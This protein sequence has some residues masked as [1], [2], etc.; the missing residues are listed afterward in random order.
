MARV[1]QHIVWR[2]EVLAYDIVRVLMVPFSLE[3][4]SKFAGKLVGFIGPKTSKHHIAHT[5]MKLAFPDASEVQIDK[6]LKESW[7]RM[8]RTFGEFPLLGRIKVF[9]ENSNVEVAGLEIL[10]KLK[11]EKKGAVLIS[12]HFANWELMAAVFSQAKLPVR[13]TYRPT[14]NPYFDKRIRAQRAAYGIELMV[15]KSGPKG[16][17]ELIQALRAGDSVALLNDQKFNAGLEIPFFGIPAMT[18]PGPTRL[19]MQTGAPLIPMSITRTNGANF[20][21]TIHEEIPLAN[22]GN[23]TADIKATVIKI[24]EFIEDQIRAHP[25]D[26]F[27]VHRRWPKELYK[28]K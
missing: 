14:N 2:L 1:F 16:A 24:T 15:A 20:R 8:G 11:R 5:N 27:W 7:N 22:T 6:W 13:V 12:G 3:Q 4:V 21:V 25:A 9:E 10:E 23:R 28:K 19:A 17:K 26:W 18:A